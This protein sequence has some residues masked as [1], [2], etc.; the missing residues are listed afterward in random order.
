MTNNQIIEIAKKYLGK[1]V[2]VDGAFGAQCVDFSNRVAMD[3]DGTRFTGNAIDMPYTANH[4]KWVWIRNTETL[5]PE[6]GDIFVESW[7]SSHPYGHTG[8]VLDATLTSMHVLEQNYDG[9]MYVIENNR[10]YSKDGLVGVWRFQGG[11]NTSSTKS[12]SQT[13]AGTYRVAADSLRVRSLPS[14][15]GEVVASYTKGQTLNLDSW[16]T[17]AEGYVWGRYTSTSG[18]TRFVAIGRS[19]GKTEGDDY[20]VKF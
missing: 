9:K 16:Y 2:D 1:S 12:T 3:A 10:A 19:T 11:D 14:T 17:V 7:A 8:I 20:L 6:G 13:F 18:K 15:A 4:G 5:V